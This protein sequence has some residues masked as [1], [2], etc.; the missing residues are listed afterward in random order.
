MR[1]RIPQ[2]EKRCHASQDATSLRGR[3]REKPSAGLYHCRRWRKARLAF[4]A[5]NPLCVACE[6]EGKVTVATVVDHV[7]PHRGDLGLF[8]D[9]GNWSSLCARC[10]SLKTARGL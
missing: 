2:A 5:K 8:W 3:K 6:A 1:G 7:V 10:H 9:V 4:L